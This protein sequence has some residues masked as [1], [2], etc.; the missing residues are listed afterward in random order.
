MLCGRNSISAIID[1]K[2]VLIGDSSSTWMG[3]AI[4][5]PAIPKSRGFGLRFAEE[6]W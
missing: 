2:V 6:S 1:A 3:I 5:G 4:A